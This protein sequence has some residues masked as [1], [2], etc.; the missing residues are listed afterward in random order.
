MIPGDPT[1]IVRATAAAG[2]ANGLGAANAALI[3]GSG[4]V[5]GV[6]ALGGS[7]SGGSS[8]SGFSQSS[9]TSSTIAPTA[10]TQ[11]TQRV[12]NI[13]LPDSGFVTVDSVSDILISLA[14]NNEVIQIAISEVL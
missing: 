2:Y 7:S 10:P 5:T 1:S 4:I 6:G 11:S 14:G 3:I 8:I 13:D 12:F 9:G